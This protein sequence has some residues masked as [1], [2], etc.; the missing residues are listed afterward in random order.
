MRHPHVDSGLVNNVQP[1]SIYLLSTSYW[2]LPPATVPNTSFNDLFF[3]FGFFPIWGRRIEFSISG[4]SSFQ[5][6][7]SPVS[8]LFYLYLFLLRFSILFIHINHLN[9]LI[10]VLSSRKSG[11]AFLDHVSPPYIRTR[12]MTSFNDGISYYPFRRCVTIFLLLLSHK[13][14]I[15]RLRNVRQMKWSCSGHIEHVKDDRCTSRVTTWR[16]YDATL[17]SMVD[18]QWGHWGPGPGP[19]TSRGPPNSQQTIF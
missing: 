13:A 6:P 19:P 14:I 15:H 3:L 11:S 18:Q 1:L 16:P 7:R 9:I 17:W 4:A 8:C 10:S 12:L 2:S 5:Y